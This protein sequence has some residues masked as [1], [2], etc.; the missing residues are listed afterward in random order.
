MDDEEAKKLILNKKNILVTS[1]SLIALLITYIYLFEWQ[2][3]SYI[4][5]ENKCIEAK[6]NI[7]EVVKNNIDKFQE[8]KI[9]KRGNH[10]E[11]NFI[12][13]EC[14]F[15]SYIISSYMATD[16]K[17]LCEKYSNM[18]SYEKKIFTLNTPD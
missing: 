10:T 3:N 4:S 8:C 16:N 17:N 13:V 12:Y 18:N 1:I 7:D 11:S 9:K 14:G 5:F 6:G 2:K 15:G